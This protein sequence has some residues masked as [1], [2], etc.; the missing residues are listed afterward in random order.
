MS[1][2]PGSTPT[3]ERIRAAIRE[4]PEM[5]ARAITLHYFQQESIDVVAAKMRITTNDARVLIEAA[6]I[7]LRGLMGKCA[8]GQDK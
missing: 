4:L 3:A 5:Q 8:G 6:L 7:N 1:L 2:P